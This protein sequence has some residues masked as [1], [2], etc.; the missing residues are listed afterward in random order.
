[1]NEPQSLQELLDAAA[2]RHGLSMRQLAVKA[3]DADYRVVDTTLNAIRNGT[4]KSRPREETVRAIGWLAGVSDE[5]AFTA[6]GLP[7]PG[8]PFADELPP[9]VDT[10]TPKKRKVVIELLRVLIDDEEAGGE[11]DQRS[12]PKTPAG[13]GPASNVHAL[14]PPDQ[15]TPPPPAGLAARNLGTPSR[16][17]QIRKRQDD[18]ADTED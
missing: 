16:G 3:R 6:A 11:H 13:P 8:P 15:G 1:M 9:G 12:A 2:A 5:V 4:Y 14:N 10:L 7:V 18:D 17:Q